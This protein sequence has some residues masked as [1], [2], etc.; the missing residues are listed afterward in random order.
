MRRVLTR[1]ATRATPW[2]KSA[3]VAATVL[4]RGRIV[5]TWSQTAGKQRLEVAVEPLSRWSEAEHLPGVE[6]EAQAV[7]AHLGLQ[8]ADVTIVAE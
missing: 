6:R 3:F 5:A 1:G 7:A 2:R 8:G 4:A